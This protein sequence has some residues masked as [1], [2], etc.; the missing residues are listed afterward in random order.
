MNQ[1]QRTINE[2]LKVLDRSYHFKENIIKFSKHE[3][4]I[5]FLAKCLVCYEYSKNGI[6]FYTE[7]IF[8]RNK[9]RCDIFV[10]IWNKAVEVVNTE[11][12]L[13]IEKKKNNYPVDVIFLKAEDILKQKGVMFK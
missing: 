7:C 10:P 4:F 6:D 2:S 12:E 11:T 3:S 13:S 9:L 1:K 5:H 8:K